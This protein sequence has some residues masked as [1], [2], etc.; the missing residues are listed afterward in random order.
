MGDNKIKNDISDKVFGHNL[1]EETCSEKDEI[2]KIISINR[3]IKI[4]NDNKRELQ[5]NE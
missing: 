4:L 5:S 1:K 3:F 2:Y